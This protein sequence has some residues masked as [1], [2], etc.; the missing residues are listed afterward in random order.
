[1][2][3]VRF[4]PHHFLCAIGYQGKGYSEAFTENMTAIVVDRLR[5]PGGDDTPIQVVGLADD[6]C[7]PCPKRQGRLCSNQAAISRLDRAHATAL[8]LTPH[9]TLTWGAAKARIRDHVPPGH[10]TTLCQGCQWLELGLC[11]AALA[12]LHAEPATADSA[13]QA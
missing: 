1:M 2:A 10:L 5:A 9:E 7:G 8:K 11:E 12:K 6:I 3:P 4:R 13:T